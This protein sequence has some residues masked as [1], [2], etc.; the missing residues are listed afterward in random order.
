MTGP[1]ALFARREL[2]GGLKGFRIFVACL[3]LGVAAIAGVGSLASAIEAGLKA[4][5]RT[6]L[7]GDVDIRLI[8][9][10]ATEDQVA[11][12]RRNS[13]G[14]SAIVQM[15]AM[16]IRADGEARRLIELK[17]V[18][19]A[20]PLT[21][22]FETPDGVGLG[23]LAQKDGHWG[24]IAAPNLVDRLALSPGDKV[25]IGEETFD[26]RTTY[27]T[28]P[29]KSTQAF[30]LGPRVFIALDALAGTELEQPGSLIRYHYRVVLPPGTD[31][32]AWTE[33]LNAAFPDAGW[34]VRALDD[35]APNIQTFVDRVGL[36]L[37]LVGLTALLVGG[38]GVGN[39]VR[40]FLAQRTATIAT[41][42][43]LGAPTRTIFATYLI[44]VAVLALAGIVIGLIIGGVGPALITP[45]LADKLPVEARAGFYPAPL[46][47]AA[48]F[49]F[50]TTLVFALWPL[51]KASSVPAAT[52]FRD[53][54]NPVTARPGP[55]MTIALILAVAALAGLAVFSADR[56]LVALA[57]T[58]GSVGTLLAFRA[59][60][61]GAMALARRLPRPRNIRVALALT[62]LYRPGAPT[63]SVVVSLGLGLTVLIAVAMVEGNLSRQVQETFRGEAPGYFFIDI[64]PDQIDGFRATMD[65]FD[66]LDRYNTVPMLRGRITKLAGV[67]VEEITPDPDV[68]W[69][70]RG[71]RGITWSRTPPE[72]G[73]EVV[74]GNWW[75]E[76]YSD[77]SRTLVSFDANAA[78]LLGLKVGDTITVN[79]L[80]REIVAEIANLREID[81]TSLGINFVMVFSPGLIESA[82]QMYLATAHL[83]PD[84]EVALEKAVTDQ[85]PNVSAIR[86]K[87][88]LEGVDKILKDLATAVTAIAAIA[89]VAGILVLAGAV[90]AGHSRRIYESVVL[91]VLGATR[92]DVLIAY[93]LEFGLLGLTTAMIA[94]LVGGL[95]AF[96]VIEE[97]MEADWIF[98]PE[99]ALITVAVALAATLTFGFAGT[100]SALGK[101]AAPLLRNE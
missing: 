31:I 19:N 82:P 33:A 38:V 78:E 95:A 80:G 14:V 49:G 48:A 54:L 41:L 42:K 26:F 23:D 70:L 64:Q 73:S 12:L 76:D 37:T 36:F 72:S 29:D 45:L 97:V 101:K 69:I 90:A 46:I 66:G 2:R 47:L 58:A 9:R 18:D 5:G 34:R 27:T 8:H 62:N 75:P 11:Y 61:S 63:G 100:W 99:A 92:R 22:T 13:D 88:V 53:L 50:L 68:A 74:A 59:A 24:L 65:N 60:A 79:L 17:A 67:P 85:F 56:P 4:D 39:S 3:A 71:D 52:L 21:G 87:E 55:R 30:E 1:A 94:G 7:G 86:V 83:D 91:K 15:R 25:R 81:W 57:F 10:P 96:V 93:L 35:A 77:T 16:A 44:Q 6:L 98:V 43:C 32:A 89:I 51:A 40:A 28:E 84:R 20:Y